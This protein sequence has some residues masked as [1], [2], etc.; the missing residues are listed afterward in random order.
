[1]PD[2]LT[3]E[4][5]ASFVCGAE[6][7]THSACQDEPFYEENEGKQYCVLHFPGKEKSADFEKAF[8]RKR[9]N[10]DF[11]FRGVWFPDPL[12]FLKVEFEEDVIF[13]AATFC[14]SV[15]FSETTFK[16]AVYFNSATFSAAADFRSAT[17]NT[18]AYFNSANF[19]CPAYF[20]AATFKA[21]ANFR[22]ATFSALADFSTGSFTVAYFSWATFTVASYFRSATFGEAANFGN[23]TFG[24]PAE[25]R[26]ATFIAVAN[27]GQATF[28]AMAKFRG[29]TF[30]KEANFGK[31]AFGGSAELR[32]ATFTGA[33]HFKLA[34]FAAVASFRAATF[35]GLANFNAVIFCQD[36]EF[37]NCALS[38]KVDFSDVTFRE[39]GK[40][41]GNINTPV[42]SSTSSLDLQFA[43]IEKPNRVSFHTLSLQPHWFVNV[44]AR[45]FEFINV[46]WRFKAGEQI[47]DLSSAGFS[48][49]TT[50]HQLL[51]IACRQLAVN[52]EDNHRYEEAS[53][54]RYMAMDARRRE[55]WRG[56][57]FWKLSWWYYLASGYG[58]R[59]F[60][61]FV[62]LL[63]ILFLF[64]LLY[65]C[66][67]FTRWEPKLASEGDAISAKRDDVGA[68]LKFSRA[69]AY[70]AGV[71]TLQKPEPR[72]ATTAAQTV[73]L[74]ETILGPV[75]AALLALAIRRKFMR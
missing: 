23:A 32:S 63:G 43:K 7:W 35:G 6:K 70:S 14:E 68:P 25:F 33:A 12:S 9:E 29:A 46:K 45:K 62:V 41:T 16:A 64:A 60:R 4:P 44:D 58:E 54:F 8:Q 39:Q 17:F 11:N 1:M 3:S 34:T 50:S 30:S 72:P 66:V 53:R 13:S 67:G 5:E 55:K 75:Q 2:S 51:A 49:S 15:D 24:A 59:M 27:F 22:S 69:L 19:R 71:I 28:S 73:V 57:A 18:Q 74:L 37:N 26:S 38:G 42:F 10:K 52:A 65:T 36:A 48:V 31:A 21:A 61:A 20:S 40:F 56:C 47:K